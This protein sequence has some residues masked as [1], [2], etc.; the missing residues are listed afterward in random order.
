MKGTREVACCRSKSM[1]SVVDQ[2]RELRQGFERQCPME[3]L[4]FWCGITSL[5]II[6]GAIVAYCAVVVLLICALVHEF[7]RDFAIPMRPIVTTLALGF[8]IALVA[9]PAT[10]ASSE[11]GRNT[12]GS[13]TNRETITTGASAAGGR[14]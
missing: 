8:V 4:E 10:L 14:P 9:T 1:K 2:I 12:Q 6:L 11:R 7:W 13:G 3:R 5:V